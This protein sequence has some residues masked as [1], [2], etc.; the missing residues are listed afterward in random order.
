MG[1]FIPLGLDGRNGFLDLSKQFEHGFDS[2]E[3]LALGVIDGQPL[4]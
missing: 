2:L 1:F 4:T 3:F